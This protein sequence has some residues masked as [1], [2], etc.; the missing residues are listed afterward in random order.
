[1]VA[2]S[3]NSN[4]AIGV[5]AWCL[6]WFGEVAALAGPMILAAGSW[7]QV[8]GCPW[9]VALLVSSSCEGLVLLPTAVYLT[10]QK[11]CGAEASGVSCLCQFILLSVQ[12]SLLTAGR[13]VCRENAATN[14]FVAYLW[15]QELFLAILLGWALASR[16]YVSR[17]S[18][19]VASPHDRGL[20][21][22]LFDEL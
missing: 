17:L 9:G 13:D 10:H 3:R 15:I 19:P 12:G 11:T 1:M 5:S 21:H 22:V 7:D 4:P 16:A 14:A 8:A 2:N 20:Q 6:F 18:L